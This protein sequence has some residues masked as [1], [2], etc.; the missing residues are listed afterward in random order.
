MRYTSATKKHFY[1]KSAL[2]MILAL[3][4]MVC[5]FTG[6]RKTV[7]ERAHMDNEAAPEMPYSVPGFNMNE[8]IYGTT[9][10]N[11]L[12]VLCAGSY[13]GAFLED[14]TDEQVTDI[15][16]IIVRNN[17]SSLVEYGKIELPL[18]DKRTATFI[19]SGLP[20]GAS[21][22][23]QESSRMQLGEA[24]DKSAFV[25]SECALPGTIVLDFGNDFEIYTDDGVLNIRNISGSDITSDVSV[26]YK[27]FE[28]GLFM[29]GITYRARF[30]GGV[31]AD[32][33]VQAL[34]NHFWVDT[35]AIL[36]MSYAS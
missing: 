35:S 1:S 32:D 28:Y 20:V 22:L 3:F 29:G 18:S 24:R 33:I 14:G 2:C 16:A 17:G 5:A 7:K 9:F 25:L 26:F 21:I 36:Y 10:D 30:T 23:I 13:S 19:F 6:C 4:L 31:K 11:G 27:N 15:L 34:Q 12:Q 8:S